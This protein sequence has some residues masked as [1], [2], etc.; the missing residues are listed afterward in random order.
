[1]EYEGRRGPGPA[2]ELPTTVAQA[3]DR[4]REVFERLAE[5]RTGADELLTDMLL[6]T[7]ELATNAIRHGGGLTGFGVRLEADA[8][9]LTVADASPEFPATLPGNGPATPGGFGWPLICRLAKHVSI[10]PVPGG[11]KIIEVLLPLR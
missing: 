2:H 11:G 8:L 10:T 9:V 6:V 1:M 4:V 7:S 3:R 5:R